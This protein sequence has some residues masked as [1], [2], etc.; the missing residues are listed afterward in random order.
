MKRQGMP[1]MPSGMPGGMPEMPG[2]M[3]GMPGVPEMP[4]GMP[5]MPGMPGGFS[6]V[7]FIQ[8]NKIKFNYLL[9]TRQLTLY[10]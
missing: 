10:D 9:K 7:R 6:R 1:E 8:S 4:G 5:G 2:G 3:P